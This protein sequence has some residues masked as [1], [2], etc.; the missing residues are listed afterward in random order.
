MTD[1][2]EYKPLD[3]ATNPLG[4]F[5]EKMERELGIHDEQKKIS[6]PPPAVLRQEREE[7]AKKGR[8]RFAIV[9]SS[10]LG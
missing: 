7:L 9:L 5:D 6:S 10:F 1:N 8:S 2:A 4:L 3:P